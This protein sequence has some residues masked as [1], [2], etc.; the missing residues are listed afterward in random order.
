MSSIFLTHLHIGDRR[1][2]FRDIRRNKRW[3]AF[4][5]LV[6]VVLILISA[7]LFFWFERSE[8]IQPFNW[9]SSLYFTVINFTTV[10]FGDIAPK[11]D[12]GRITRWLT[13][14]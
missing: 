1:A 2:V 14:S 4:S 8:Q 9:F 6:I 5:F 11:T 3:I 13:P 12:I 7:S 10:G